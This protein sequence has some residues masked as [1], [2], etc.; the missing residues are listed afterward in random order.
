MLKEGRRASDVRL[1]E[2]LP[3]RSRLDIVHPA[4]LEIN[5]EEDVGD[6]VE[7]YNLAH[8]VHF[9]RQLT[10]VSSDEVAFHQLASDEV[11][12]ARAFFRFGDGEAGGCEREREGDDENY[13]DDV[14]HF[15][16]LEPPQESARSLMNIFFVGAV[17]KKEAGRYRRTTRLRIGFSAPVK[18]SASAM[19]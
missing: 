5:D 19:D 12:C 13:F 16:L 7:V 14:F 6:A 15:C 3:E 17:Y 4:I 18:G 9:N 2:A 1:H 8:A 10:A 11:D